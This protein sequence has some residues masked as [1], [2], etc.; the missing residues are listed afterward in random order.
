[1]STKM[2]E[3]RDMKNV[4]SEGCTQTSAGDLGPAWSAQFDSATFSRLSAINTAWPRFTNRGPSTFLRLRC[5]LLHS[6]S[7]ESFR[8]FPQIGP[9]L[10]KARFRLSLGPVKNLGAPCLHPRGRAV[11]V[12]MPGYG[13]LKNRGRRQDKDP[14]LML[15]CEQF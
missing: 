2:F 11:A 6:H 5:L 1:M 7:A 13:V 14:R 3:S 4:Q 8:Q 10:A 12:G 15:Q 9:K